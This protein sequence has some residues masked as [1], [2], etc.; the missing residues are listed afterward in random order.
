MDEVACGMHHVVA[1]ARQVDRKSGRPLDHGATLLLAWG[2][3]SEGQLGNRSFEDSATP[4]VV[5][6]PKGRQVLQVACGG[7]NTMAVC[8]TDLRRFESE[9]R[10]DADAAAR[11][12]LSLSD[13]RPP[14]GPSRS[15]RSTQQ[16]GALLASGPADFVRRSFSAVMA[17]P[18]ASSSSNGSGH[19]GAAG[20]AGTGLAGLG[21]SGNSLARLS[22]SSV[23]S[24]SGKQPSSAAQA[25]Y[26]T[27]RQSQQQGAVAAPRGMQRA[28]SQQQLVRPR[29]SV[30]RADGGGSGRLVSLSP[31]QQQQ[32]QT[33]AMRRSF[34]SSR[35]FT[36]HSHFST[37]EMSSI[38]SFQRPMS[39]DGALPE[40]AL[41]EACY[42]AYEVDS[43]SGINGGGLGSGE[44]HVDDIRSTSSVATLQ[45]GGPGVIAGARGR[46]AGLS[47]WNLAKLSWACQ[48]CCPPPSDRAGGAGREE[49]AD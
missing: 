4:L 25:L 9:C 5:D 12:L 34:L 1:T 23:R 2:R 24:S 26:A 22:G 47:F 44:L 32:Q 10:E 14:P 45:V 28:G 15:A 42:A 49:P 11:A 13:G 35:S 27:I 16:H 48:V 8:E 40:G 30:D 3:G 6:A 19:G 43:H 17:G 37:S 7:C 41:P 31:G 20:A 29:T 33:V 18:P 38:S 36:A 39:D 21:G 46:G